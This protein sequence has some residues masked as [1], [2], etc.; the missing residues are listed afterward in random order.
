MDSDDFTIVKVLSSCTI[1][2]R[3]DGILVLRQAA[4]KDSLTVA[5]IKEQLMVIVAIQ[6]GDLS[7]YLTV[8]DKLIKLGNEEK[9]LIRSSLPE[10]AS[11]AALVTNNL[12]VGFIFNVF[13]SLYRPSIPS[14]IFNSETEA[15]IWLKEK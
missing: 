2:K 14:K 5:E 8:A 11:K 6:K 10:F 1:Y 9:M 15:L 12:L 3:T 7:P 13:L 4:G